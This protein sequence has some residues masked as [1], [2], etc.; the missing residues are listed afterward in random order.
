MSGGELDYVYRRVE[1]AVPT[2]R[3][4]VDEYAGARERALLIAFAAHLERV[5]VCLHDVEWYLSND[6]DG[7]QMVHALTALLGTPPADASEAQP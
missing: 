1:E 6:T 7:R 3:A 4:Y 2:I 5:A